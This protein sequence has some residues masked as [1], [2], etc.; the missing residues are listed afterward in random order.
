MSDDSVRLDIAGM[1]CANCAATV[2]EAIAG[3]AAV[4]AVTVNSATDTAS[5]T[6]APDAD[7]LA[8]VVDAVDAA[9]YRVIEASTTIP[10]SGMTCA[11]CAQTIEAALGGEPG[12]IDV[13]VNV[14]TDEV[15]VRYLPSA[16]DV[17]ALRSVI[18]ASGY[19]PLEARG[20]A[21]PS[22]VA[23]SELPGDRLTAHRD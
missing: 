2:E 20:G 9:G 23:S 10:V 3:V 16:V 5:V 22:S 19:T 18:T 14:A 21:R 8:A 15:S 4:D 6:V 17:E 7:A 1:T 11:S 13:A 12:V